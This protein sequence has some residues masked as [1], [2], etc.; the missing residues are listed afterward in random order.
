MSDH[1]AFSVHAEPLLLPF[2]S[3]WLPVHVRSF[4][5]ADRVEQTLFAM[6]GFIGN[7]MDFAELAPVLARR[8]I[9]VICPDMIG[10]G[11]SGRFAD[12]RRYDLTTVLRG[13]I[14]VFER[15]AT[16]NFQVLGMH[17]GALIAAL[18][19]QRLGLRA[20]RLV[21]CGLPLEFDAGND[22]IIR[23]GIDL[24]DSRFAEAAEAVAR[25]A[26]SPEFGGQLPPALAAARLRQDGDALA[27]VHDPGIA[28][29]TL[30]FAGRSYDLRPMLRDA[31]AETVLI[32]APGRQ[33]QALPQGSRFLASE[34][35]LLLSAGSPTFLMIAGLLLTE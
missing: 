25:L 13:A 16:G 26:A 20:R 33:P 30:R 7:G 11:A 14:A 32:D 19:L 22:P 24:G 10:R 4:T 28:E 18:A 17:W 9:R 3:E 34:A 12:P 31:A 29:A 2:G 5:P 27:L 8:G 6:H 1:P 23:Y 35:P 15:Y 21:A